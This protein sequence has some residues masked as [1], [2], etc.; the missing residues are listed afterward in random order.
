MGLPRLKCFAFND[1]QPWSVASPL[2]EIDWSPPLNSEALKWDCTCLNKSDP[3]YQINCASLT[4]SK[5]SKWTRFMC[6]SLGPSYHHHQQRWWTYGVIRLVIVGQWGECPSSS[7]SDSTIIDCFSQQPI[8]PLSLIREQSRFV[9]KIYIKVTHIFMWKITSSFDIPNY[10]N[11]S[12][13]WISF[14]IIFR[15][16]SMKPII[17]SVNY[18]KAKNALLLQTSTNKYNVMAERQTWKDHIKMM[19]I[20]TMQWCNLQIYKV[21]HL[22]LSWL[23]ENKNVWIH[24]KKTLSEMTLGFNY[25]SFS[26]FTKQINNCICSRYRNFDL[27][28]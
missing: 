17:I 26:L 21:D 22:I 13:P 4:N 20:K 2:T 5:W 6:L 3:W 16:C 11:C 9:N 19:H 18:L 24:L 14:K 1:P 27:V 23:K 28:L 15:G 8:V 25:N 7:D 12:Q 10:I